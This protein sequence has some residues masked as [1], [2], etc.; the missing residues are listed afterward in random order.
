MQNTL[1]H[2]CR[3]PRLLGDLREK[4]Y[5][6]LSKPCYLMLQVTFGGHC[7]ILQKQD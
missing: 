4:Y 1:E 5:N 3:V 2:C 7:L 6:A